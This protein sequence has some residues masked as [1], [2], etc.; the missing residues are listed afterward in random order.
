[1][2]TPQ[3]QSRSVFNG[4]AVI[5]QITERDCA[6]WEAFMSD[7]FPLGLYNK[8]EAAHEAV[9]IEFLRRRNGG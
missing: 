6:R 1:M 9:W 4:C 5:G 3:A 2:T 8:P 7:G